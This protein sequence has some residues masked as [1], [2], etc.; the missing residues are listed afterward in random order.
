M[1]Y[2]VALISSYSIFS[3]NI[4]QLAHGKVLQLWH[5]KKKK[6][7]QTK[8]TKKNKKYLE[9]KVPLHQFFCVP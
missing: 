9:E 5:T 6:T 8:K 4:L 2:A 3:Y 7:K 1:Q